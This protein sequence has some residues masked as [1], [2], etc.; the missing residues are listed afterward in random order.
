MRITILISV[1]L[2]GGF[3]VSP[4]CVFA[5]VNTF[6]SL[7]SWNAA[8]AATPTS[9]SFEGIA[10]NGGY[11]AQPNGFT[12]NGLTFT[13]NRS[14]SNGYMF[15]LGQGFTYAGIS[16]LTT[17]QS[18]LQNNNIVITLPQPSTAVAFVIGTNNPPARVRLST[19]DELTVQTR[20]FP[21][22]AFF[23]ITSAQP[24]TSLEIWTGLP[25]GFD[26]QTFFFVPA[27]EP[28]LI[29]VHGS[30]VDDVEPG[31]TWSL[32]WLAGRNYWREYSPP[33]SLWGGATQTLDSPEEDFV[34][35]A[36]A[37]RRSHFIV[38][39]N[40]AAAWWDDEAAGRVASEIL[41]ATNG[42]Y[43]G[44]DNAANRKD[45][46]RCESSYLSGGRFLVIAHSMGA[47]VMDFILGNARPDDPYYNSAGAFDQVAARIAGVISVGGAH[48]GSGLADS[49]CG[50]G[51]CPAT[52]LTLN[53]CTPA[54]ESLQTG[55]AFQV[56]AYSN[57]PARP[58]W[59]IGGF[60]GIAGPSACLDG[61]DDGVL[62]L[63]SQLACRTSAGI[64][65]SD[66][67]DN[68]HKMGAK[69][70]INIDVADE[71]HDDEKNVRNIGNR[72][73]KAI[74]DGVWKC[75]GKAC[76][77]DSTVRTNL[78]TAAL[79]DLLISEKLIP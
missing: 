75:D 34:A 78:S 41:R 49:I 25:I 19:G 71:N 1:V 40:G 23:G 53:K 16:V 47:T 20:P 8:T 61:Q 27:S 44:P 33:N 73:R 62:E 74:A 5:E 24:I 69:N 18:T 2:L 54:R 26:L 58:I 9:V 51:L 36:T 3:V 56:S 64:G 31:Y 22:L 67:C 45:R 63:S 35:G 68:D 6:T 70:Y 66:A 32:D 13:I 65:I 59:L 28:C 12:R 21:Q 38:R 48:R 37:S 76:P 52:A 77:P 72:T 15:V 43:D 50:L 30:R 14:E 29:F 7:S 57:S 4:E 79:I 46:A 55:D 42:E 11:V 39:Y 10:A 60:K 17:Q